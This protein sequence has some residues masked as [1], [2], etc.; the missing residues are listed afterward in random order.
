MPLTT[1][2]ATVH[3]I[4]DASDTDAALSI[5]IDGPL[6]RVAQ[7]E[8]IRTLFDETEHR[9]FALAVVRPVQRWEMPSCRTRVHAETSA[10]EF[11]RFRYVLRL[12][13]DDAPPYVR[14]WSVVTLDDHTDFSDALG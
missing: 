1:A 6:G 12:S 5:Y 2:V 7:L 8:G 10:H 4:E 11:P 3:I 13:F 14:N 9:V